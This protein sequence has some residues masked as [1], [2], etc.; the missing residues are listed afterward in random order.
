M[1]K[2][3]LAIAAAMF[4]AT[5]FAQAP[6]MQGKG[7]KQLQ[8]GLTPKGMTEQAMQQFKAPLNAQAAFATPKKAT[9]TIDTFVLP[10]EIITEQPEGTLYGDLYRNSSAF[11]VYFYSVYYTNTDGYANDVVKASDGT[12]YIKN[13][14]ATL[15]SG[16]WI[17]AKQGEGDTLEVE[18]PQLVYQQSYGD[19]EYNYYAWR[20]KINDDGDWYVPDSTSQ[21][22]K[23]VM[24]ND[25]V[26][27]VGDNEYSS[28]PSYIIGLA[29][30]EGEWAGYGTYA[31]AMG[32]SNDVASKPSSTDNAFTAMMEYDEQ[33]SSYVEKDTAEVYVASTP[34]LVD[35]VVEGNDIYVGGLDADQSDLWLK[36]TINGSKATFKNGQ[37]MGV[38]K[39]NGCHVYFLPTTSYWVFSGY[40]DYGYYVDAELSGEDIVLDYD[41]DTKQ[42]KGTGELNINLGK[43]QAGSLNFYANPNINKFNEVAG[44][45]QDPIME[46]DYCYDYDSNYGYGRIVFM[47]SPYDVNGNYMNPG[48]VFYNLWLDEDEEP[49]VLYSD[50]Y[51]YQTEDEIVDIP[52]NYSDSWDI[53]AYTSGERVVYTYWQGAERVGVQMINRSAGEEHKSNIAWYYYEETTGINSAAQSGAD[54]KS[55]SYTDLSGRR[56]ATPSKGVYVKTMKMA[57]GSVKSVKVVK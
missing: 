55:V 10:T 5:S 46:E 31:D 49:Y 12:V 9:S 18:L 30:E 7:L 13:P 3:Y 52:Y 36:G 51:V 53:Y 39:A 45:P 44:A 16:T 41:A 21:V 57:D 6:A 1:R 56:V 22:V 11:M 26:I 25:S 14:I 27:F 24:R 20:M 4:A 2:L 15:T 50:E 33:N 35:V 28:L 8:K 23:Y 48:K 34:T 37:Y 19:T 29:D 47:T 17:K 43:N 38:D 32:K 54:V 42:L 40:S